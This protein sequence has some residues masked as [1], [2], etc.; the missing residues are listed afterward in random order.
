MLLDPA[1][2]REVVRLVDG[3]F[4]GGI[5]RPIA[6]RPVAAAAFS[7]DLGRG[8]EWIALA[9][10]DGVSLWRLGPVDALIEETCARVS[11]NLEP[12]EWPLD[13]PPPVTCPGR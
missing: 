11:R 10:D 1:S 8:S 5:D 7:P 4:V 13:G 2:G 12:D 9:T 3:V 6:G